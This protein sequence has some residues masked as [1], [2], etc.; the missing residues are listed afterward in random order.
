[1][2]LADSPEHDAF[3]R[4]TRAFLEANRADWPMA[5]ASRARVLAWQKRLITRACAESGAVKVPRQQSAHTANAMR[6]TAGRISRNLIS[7]PYT[8]MPAS[9][10]PPTA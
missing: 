1:M 10:S 3:R 5:G 7:I 4:E 2:N 6:L 9:G 8:P